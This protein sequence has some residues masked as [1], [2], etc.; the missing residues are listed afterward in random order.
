MAQG[1]L[2]ENAW[3]AALR[4]QAGGHALSVHGHGMQAPGWP[5]LYVHL[6]SWRGWLELKQHDGRLSTIQRTVVRRLNSAVPGT[7]FVLRADR[8]GDGFAVEDHDGRVLARA[9]DRW[10]LRQVLSAVAGAVL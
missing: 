6:G 5:D 7:A 2:G 3:K 1:K 4:A 10:D 9:G 8:H